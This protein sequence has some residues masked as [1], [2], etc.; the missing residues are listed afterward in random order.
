M[1]DLYYGTDLSVFVLCIV[2]YVSIW[3][4]EIH[5]GLYCCALSKYTEKRINPPTAVNV[6]GF[7]AEIGSNESRMRISELDTTETRSTLK[8]V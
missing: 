1:H 6:C 3:V 7:L 8:N 5:D 4:I 2:V